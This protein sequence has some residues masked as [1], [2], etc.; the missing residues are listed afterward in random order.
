MKNILLVAA[1]LLTGA[2]DLKENE[3]ITKFENRFKEVRTISATFSQT[4]YDA[5]FGKE[6]KSSGIVL[7]KKPLKM[8]WRYDKPYE[9]TILSDGEN[10][11]F[12]FPSDHQVLVESVGNIVDSR[13]PVLFLAGGIALKELF[14]ISLEQSGRKDRM[15]GDIRLELIPKEKSVSATKVILTV[16]GKSW[17]IKSFSIFDWTGNRTDIE[18]ANMKINETIGGNEFKFVLPDGSE[19]IHMPKP[20]FGVKE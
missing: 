7:I 14:T 19:I 13:S 20:E 12:Q 9:Q 2:S 6:E 3:I 15:E 16:D 18:F 1:L 11:Y 8:V 17:N 5:T 10:L 4:F